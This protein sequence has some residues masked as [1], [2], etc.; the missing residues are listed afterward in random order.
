M[1]AGNA[2]MAA[3]EM[4]DHR[5]GAGQT[6]HPRALAIGRQGLTARIFRETGHHGD[7]RCSLGQQLLTS[8]QQGI[9]ALH[10]APTG[11][12]RPLAQA[13]PQRRFGGDHRTNLQAQRGPTAIDHLQMALPQLRLHAPI[14][15][16][17]QPLPPDGPEA[18]GTGGKAIQG[19]AL[20]VLDAGIAPVQGGTVHHIGVGDQAATGGRQQP[21]RGQGIPG[22]A[23]LFTAN[24]GGDHQQRGHGGRHRSS[25]AHRASSI[26]TTASITN[27][28]PSGLGSTAV[29]AQRRGRPWAAKACRTWSSSGP[30][31]RSSRS[32]RGSSLTFG[33]GRTGLHRGHPPGQP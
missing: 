27:T 21:R 3:E 33:T 29:I 32:S 26:T 1:G 18:Q 5:L 9:G 14:Q 11:P 23:A 12:T 24:A 31:W 25:G 17:S 7:G 6:I 13:H 8:A 2:E 22:I 28:G 16:Q 20:H 10:M 15:Q 30:P 19:G 4:A